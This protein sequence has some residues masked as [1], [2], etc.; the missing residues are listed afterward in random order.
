M[1][2]IGLSGG[3]ASG[4]NLVAKIFKDLDAVVFDADEIVH[5]LLLEDEMVVN[6]ISQKFQKSY[7]GK[8]ID[9][10]ILSAIITANPQM[11]T[12]L[13]N[14]LHPIVR[15]KYQEFIINNNINSDKLLILNIL[16]AFL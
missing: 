1:T 13:E 4:K 2:I 5:Q 16:G 6:Q 11:L 9:R 7:N 14:I 12:I 8:N 10:K 15:N 3:I